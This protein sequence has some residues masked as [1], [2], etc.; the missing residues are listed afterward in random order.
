MTYIV[1][2]N[3]LQRIEIAGGMQY[4]GTFIEHFLLK[5]SSETFVSEFYESLQQNIAGS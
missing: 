2:T 1:T 4:P 5:S 3:L